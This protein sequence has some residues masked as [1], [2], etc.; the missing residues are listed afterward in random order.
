MPIGLRSTFADAAE[1]QLDGAA[2]R[3]RQSLLYAET[4][5]GGDDCR[6]AKSRGSTGELTPGETGLSDL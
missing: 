4:G 3:L 6:R 1:R 5:H 2:G